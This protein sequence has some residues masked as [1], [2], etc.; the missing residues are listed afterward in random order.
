MNMGKMTRSSPGLGAL[1]ILLGHP[2]Q[3]S[4]SSVAC[5]SGAVYTQISPQ[6]ATGQIAGRPTAHLIRL[7]FSLSLSISPTLSLSLS[8]SLNYAWLV[9]SPPLQ[10]AFDIL[11]ENAEFCE[12]EGP[13]LAFMR[14]SSV[15]KS[16]PGAVRCPA[17]LRGVPCLGDQT[18]AVIEVAPVSMT[19]HCFQQS[20]LTG[21]QGPVTRNHLR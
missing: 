20:L 21:C 7:S 15:L 18:R 12:I 13:C 14:A 1:L 2:G 11:A 17:D 4:E 19:P 6:P 3:T 9:W 8:P 16:L 5:R 10:D